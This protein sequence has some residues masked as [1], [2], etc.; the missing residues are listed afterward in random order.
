MLHS[1]LRTTGQGGHGRGSRPCVG[2]R[3]VSWGR[4]EG[5]NVGLLWAKLSTPSIE[6]VATLGT[7][8]QMYSQGSNRRP[9]DWQTD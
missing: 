8:W 4:K 9:N 5:G 7:E 3:V 1:L 2:K 6:G